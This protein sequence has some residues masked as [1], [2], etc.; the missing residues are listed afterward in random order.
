P[1]PRALPSRRRRPPRPRERPSTARARRSRRPAA[2]R[3]AARGSHRFDSSLTSSRA[4]LGLARGLVLACGRADD[5]TVVELHL[6]DDR[7]Y[8]GLEAHVVAL[9]ERGA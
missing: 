3:R 1:S 6:V 4:G 9:A 8:G 2:R 7:G 5:A